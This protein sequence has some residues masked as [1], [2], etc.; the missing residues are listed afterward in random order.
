LG[1]PDEAFLDRPNPA[2]RHENSEIMFQIGET[3]SPLNRLSE[4]Y[5]TIVATGVDV[6]REMLR[7]WPDLERARGVVLIDEVETHL[8]P[9]WKMRIM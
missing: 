2:E 3:V 5:K 6:M 1:L 9:R 4:G 7:Y 8:H